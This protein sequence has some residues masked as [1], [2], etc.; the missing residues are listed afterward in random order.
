MLQQKS[1]LVEARAGYAKIRLRRC[2]RHPS[3][4]IAKAAAA[5]K[6][7]LSSPQASAAARNR[8]LYAHWNLTCL[9]SCPARSPP[10]VAA[11]V[12]HAP[13]SQDLL[14]G[15]FFCSARFRGAVMGAWR[16]P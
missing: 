12:E 1:S 2:A 15:R 4:K 10:P 14:T 3:I 7:A 8:H 9:S 16:Q 11:S 13:G 6:S 5:R